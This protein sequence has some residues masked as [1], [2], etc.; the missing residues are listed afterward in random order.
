M[1]LRNRVIWSDNGVLKDISDVLNNHISGTAVIPFTAAQDYLYLGAAAPFNHR[2]VE[3]KTVNALASKISEI[4]IWDG[5]TW[6]P[7]AEIIDQTLNS[8]GTLSFSKSG[9]VAWVPDKSHANWSLSDTSID[10]EEFVTGLGS[11]KVYDLF[12]VRIKL[13]ADVT[14]GFE[15]AFLGYKFANDEDLVSLW[16]LFNT[17]E[18]KTRFKSGITTWD[19]VHFEAAKQVISAIKGEQIA[20]MEGQILDWECL[21]LP[22]IHKAAEIIYGAYGSDFADEQADARKK[23]IDA[24][25]VDLFNI[26]R[27]RDARLDPEERTFRQGR[28]Y[29]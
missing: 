21:R 7:A 5:N 16:P 24:M 17:S 1:I 11:I 27:N 25:K 14:P 15:L 3:V 9:Y 6:E 22:A 2:W 8:A 26:D 4:A 29:R 20:D 12:W 13:S 23:F 10:G 19:Q 18:A 28:L